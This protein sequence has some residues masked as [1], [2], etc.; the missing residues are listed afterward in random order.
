MRVSNRALERT[1][2]V[3]LGLMLLLAFGAP[4]VAWLL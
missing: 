4:L 2:F 1:V 3:L